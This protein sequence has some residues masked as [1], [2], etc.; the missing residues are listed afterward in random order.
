MYSIFKADENLHIQRSLSISISHFSFQEYEHSFLWVHYITPLHVNVSRCNV[1]LRVISQNMKTSRLSPSHRTDIIAWNHFM[2]FQCSVT[3]AFP[4]IFNILLLYN[5][6]LVC[7]CYFGNASGIWKC[8]EIHRS[9]IKQ[10]L[11]Q[12]IYRTETTTVASKKLNW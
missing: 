1:S 8:I 5:T 9:K 6:F 11:Q 2:A 7:L 12:Y 10:Y 3:R 4:L